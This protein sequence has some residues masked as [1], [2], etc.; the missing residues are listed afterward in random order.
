MTKLKK[1]QM[2]KSGGMRYNNVR[3]ENTPSSSLQEMV[4]ITKGP[5]YS[6]P[7]WGKKFVNLTKAVK[8]IDVVQAENLID[9]GYI[10]ITD[11]INSRVLV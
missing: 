9:K 11:A 6:K 1:V 10:D 7:L 3:I 2:L 8:A 4:T 5:K